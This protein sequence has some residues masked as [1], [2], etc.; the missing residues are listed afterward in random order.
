MQIRE[1]LHSEVYKTMKNS[2]LFGV[3]GGFCSMAILAVLYVIDKNYLLMGY[4]KFT[5]LVLLAAMFIAV[6]RERNQKQDQFIA[7]YDAL[8]TAFQTF[9]IGYLIKFAFTYLL[10][11]F[12]DPSLLDIAKNKA[13]EI[14]TAHRDAQETEEIFQQR[15]TAFKD[16]N[17]G[18]GLLDIGIML[19]II[20]GFVLSLSVAGLLR[21]E[22]PEYSK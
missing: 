10:F 2:I 8:K 20:V 7:F 11:N 14:F 6:L 4:E 21:R 12:I 1:I 9:V 3:L 19:E 13:V 15:L 22:I 16:G 17:F 18:P 5:W